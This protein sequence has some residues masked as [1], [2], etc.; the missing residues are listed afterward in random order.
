MIPGVKH[1]GSMAATL[2][3]C[4]TLVTPAAAQQPRLMMPGTSPSS[5]T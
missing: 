2:V 1:I 3:V 5:P 4:V